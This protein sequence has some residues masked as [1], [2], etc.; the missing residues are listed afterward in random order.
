MLISIIIHEANYKLA[1]VRVKL[2][3]LYCSRDVTVNDRH[4]LM[5]LTTAV[6]IFL[7]TVKKK[8]EWNVLKG[9]SVTEKGGERCFFLKT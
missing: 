3:Q 5:V 8:H 1:P 7:P 4:Q 9:L 2:G 6:T